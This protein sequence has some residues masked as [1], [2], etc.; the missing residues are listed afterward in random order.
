MAVD[1]D[2]WNALDYSNP[3][4]LLNKLRPVYYRLVAGEADEEIEGTDRRRVRFQKA[5]VKRLE[6]L[7]RQLEIDVAR[8]TGKSR[9]FALVGRMR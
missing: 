9:R 7:V 2:A 5:D 4:E 1:W 8:V 3:V 6:A